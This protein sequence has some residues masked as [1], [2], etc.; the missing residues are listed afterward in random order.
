MKEIQKEYMRRAIELSTISVANGGGPFGAVIVKDGKIIA[1]SSNSVTID[2]D[3]TAHAEVNTIR[4]A[5]KALNSFELVGCEI[6][7]SC[8]PCPMCLGAIYWSRLDELYFANTKKDAADIGFDDSFIYDELNVSV[9]NRRV[10][11]SQFMRE[12]AIVAF[13][14]W[15]K[16]MDKTEY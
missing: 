5:C 7:S 15:E 4:K 11:T 3:P 1:E 10:K 12:E 9:E 16:K 13:Q 8:E 2:N 14:N 6:Y